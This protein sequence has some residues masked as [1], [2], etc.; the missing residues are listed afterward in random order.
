MTKL[1]WLCKGTS[2]FHETDDG[3]GCPAEL[4]QFCTDC[5]KLS[6]P[7]PPLFKKCFVILY[8]LDVMPLENV[9]ITASC[10]NYPLLG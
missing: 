9:M 6:P 4:C 7:S 2:L 5:D 1:T 3:V 10:L 8:L